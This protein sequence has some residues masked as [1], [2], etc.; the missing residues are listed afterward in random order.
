MTKPVLRVSVLRIDA[1]RLTAWVRLPAGGVDQPWVHVAAD[2]HTRLTYYLGLGAAE[3]AGR[4][5]TA[6]AWYASQG[7]RIV[8]V[9]LDRGVKCGP[10]P[11]TAKVLGLSVHHGRTDDLERLVELNEEVRYLDENFHRNA[12]AARKNLKRYAPREGEGGRG[13]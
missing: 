11:T 3:A 8:A 4:L 10:T 6:V 1:S 12:E 9:V 13:P 7:A 5:P 2:T